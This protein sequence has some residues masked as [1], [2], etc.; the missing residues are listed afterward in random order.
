MHMK[1]I[2]LVITLYC[3]VNFIFAN[4]NIDVN[5]TVAEISSA[6]GYYTSGNNVFSS[7]SWTLTINNQSK[8][9]RFIINENCINK[10]LSAA[11]SSNTF[12]DITLIF[13]DKIYKSKKGI[14]SKNENVWNAIDFKIDNDI[15]LFFVSDKLSIKISKESFVYNLG[16]IDISDIKNKWQQFAA[17]CVGDLIFYD[18]GY[19]NDGWRFLEASKNDISILYGYP[20]ISDARNQSNNLI[21]FGYARKASNKQNLYTNKTSLYDEN[22]TSPSIGKGITNSEKLYSLYG[23]EFFANAIGDIIQW[24]NPVSMCLNLVVTNKDDFFDDWFLPSIE[25]LEML[26]AFFKSQGNVPFYGTY[27]SSTE[28]NYSGS[29]NY[30]WCFNFLN[31]KR[32]MKK[33]SESCFV[34]AM[35]AF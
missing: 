23:D 25:E 28:A 17:S 20:C 14:L 6:T 4:I 5:D 27:W 35:R 2:L 26:Y 16:T 10:R 29:A 19:Y 9:A 1:K 15:A 3:L 13:D 32:E 12:F 24:D 30:M 31:G 11:N 34:L 8:I 18:K 7:M 22:C 33:K 21:S